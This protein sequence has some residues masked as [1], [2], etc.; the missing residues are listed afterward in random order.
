MSEGAVHQADGVCQWCGMFDFGPLFLCVCAWLGQH[1]A[2]E[3]CAPFEAL[4]QLKFVCALLALWQV[5]GFTIA[6]RALVVLELHV[7]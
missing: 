3:N 6:K 5:P 4:V 1:T 2:V 7:H